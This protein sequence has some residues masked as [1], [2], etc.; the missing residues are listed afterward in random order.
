MNARSI[1]LAQISVESLEWIWDEQEFG[2]PGFVEWLA[3][4]ETTFWITGKPASG[5]ST[6]MNF[7]ATSDQFQATLQRLSGHAWLILD[8]Y[9]DFRA[10]SQMANSMEGVLRSLLFQ[11]VK[12]SSIAAKTV[13]ADPAGRDLHIKHNDMG[14]NTLYHLVKIAVEAVSKTHRIIALLDG[15]DEYSGHCLQFI[16][17]TEHLLVYGVHKICLASRPEYL[18]HQFLTNKPH[19]KMQD[20]NHW[21]I[22]AYVEHTLEQVSTMIEL[23]MEPQSLIEDVVTL[24]EGVIL[25]TR[26]AAKTLLES[27]LSGDTEHELRA[28]LQQIP[29]ELSQ[30][31]ERLLDDVGQA[32]RLETALMLHLIR[33]ACH[34]LSPRDL[35]CALIFLRDVNLLPSWPHQ[36]IDDTTFLFRLRARTGS[37]VDIVKDRGAALD[38]VRHE[39]CDHVV[40]FHK[41][42][43]DYLTASNYIH[44]VLS[45][46]PTPIQPDQL[47]LTSFAQCVLMYS[48]SIDDVSEIRN[49]AQPD[50]TVRSETLFQGNKRLLEMARTV[51]SHSTSSIDSGM[52]LL[53]CAIANLPTYLARIVPRT[54]FDS[55]VYK[56]ALGSPTMILHFIMDQ[57][58]ELVGLHNK[59][60]SPSRS[61]CARWYDSH[62]DPD[63]VLFALSSE[64]RAILFA[65]NHDSPYIANRW[66]SQSE[67]EVDEVL[68]QEVLRA[69]VRCCGSSGGTDEI[70]IKEFVRLTASVAQYANDEVIL[71]LI[72]CISP[73]PQLEVLKLCAPYLAMNS[74]DRKLTRHLDFTWKRTTKTE[75]HRYNLY[76]PW[77]EVATEEHFHHLEEHCD[78]ASMLKIIVSSGLDVNTPCCIFGP[79]LH[80]VVEDVVLSGKDR[81]AKLIVYA[82]ET[83]K[84]LC[85]NGAD[86][87]VL[88]E[89]LTVQDLARKRLQEV[90]AHMHQHWKPKDAD[91]NPDH[92]G[93]VLPYI[94]RYLDSHTFSGRDISDGKSDRTTGKDPDI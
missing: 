31:Y 21:T 49:W 75:G 14:L 53:E 80:S 34:R 44:R 57:R 27:L 20:Y 10:G 40:L 59:F 29:T 26:I 47:W 77:I 69:I 60:R 22:R 86:P 5:K 76:L 51:F 81:G 11:F 61:S 33:T 50:Y 55:T 67:T 66:L 82:G 58:R 91:W 84:A 70:D 43:D 39:H 2:G 45:T 13:Q 63:S 30:V 92:P 18:L 52:A 83:V 64:Q 85:E 71:P 23:S 48:L 24:S 78:T 65:V 3:S 56:Q 42:L 38:H 7:L 8:F 89:G 41:T 17:M 1:Q 88:F 94:I 93:R 79:P 4:E 35:H 16:R 68:G 6:L 72:D 9:F 12:A 36:T 87:S 28:K 74:G 46:A 73:S 25:W 32:T 15:L 37:L 90:E 62:D 54:A 19:F